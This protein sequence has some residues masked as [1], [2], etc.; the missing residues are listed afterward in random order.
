MTI[1]LDT[2]VLIDALRKK[3]SAVRAVEEMLLSGHSLATSAIN[4]GEVYSGAR[5]HDHAGIQVLLSE[6]TIYSATASIARTA[7]EI[8]NKAARRGVTVELDDMIVAA[9]ALFHGCSVAT[10]NRKDFKAAGVEFY[11][12]ADN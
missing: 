4:V 10:S 3:P 1:L 9:T 6:T 11:G 8:R 12:P 7:G 5:P 2:T